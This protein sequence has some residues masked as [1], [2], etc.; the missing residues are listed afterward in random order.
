MSLHQLI[1]P[2]GIITWLMVLT[3]LLSGLKVIKLSFK[4]HRRLGIISVILAT[5]HGLLV[6]ILNS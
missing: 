1:E 6:F 2:F 3:T 4:N 5:C